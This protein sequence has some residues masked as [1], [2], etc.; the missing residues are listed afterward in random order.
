MWRFTYR[1]NCFS[2]NLL[3]SDSATPSAERISEAPSGAPLG[4]FNRSASEYKEAIDIERSQFSD[5]L[6]ASLISTS[7]T[8]SELMLKVQ[9]PTDDEEELVSVVAAKMYRSKTNAYNYLNI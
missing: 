5:K 1:G 2:L 3:I 8:P 9:L 6:E 4:R 7:S